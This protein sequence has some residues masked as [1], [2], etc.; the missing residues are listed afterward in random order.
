MQQQVSES[1]ELYI[2]RV[3]DQYLQGNDPHATEN[4]DEDIPWFARIWVDFVDNFDT[5]DPRR[6]FIRPK[7]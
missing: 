4:P 2:K 1:A 7:T 5:I 3:I 6:R